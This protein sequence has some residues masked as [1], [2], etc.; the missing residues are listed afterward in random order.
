ME[1]CLDDFG[2]DGLSWACARCPKKRSDDLHPYTTKLIE[3]YGLQRG[4]Y[5]FAADDLTL[6]EWQDLG[7]IRQALEHQPT[8]AP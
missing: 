8:K 4:G 3:L 2:E 6:D 7:K 5:P 1:K